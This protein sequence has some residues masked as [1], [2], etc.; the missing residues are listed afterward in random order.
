MISN[1]MAKRAGK[2]ETFSI[3]VD[4]ETRRILKLEAERN[5]DGNVSQM[6]AA[7]AREAQRRSAFERVMGA[8][9]RMSGE[10]R[11]AFEKQVAREVA[12]LRKKPKRAA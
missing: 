1:T 4:A 10:E 6:I 5:F 8:G 9:P 2:T 7:I 12:A 11:A 3:S